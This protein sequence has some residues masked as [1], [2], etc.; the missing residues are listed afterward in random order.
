[1]ESRTIEQR[2]LS[3]PH[4]PLPHTHARSNERRLTYVL[5][6]CPLVSHLTSCTPPCVCLPLQ[7]G[8]LFVVVGIAPLI[9]SSVCQCDTSAALGFSYIGFLVFIGPGL[10]LMMLALRPID[11]R[12][13]RGAS[14][15][16]VTFGILVG[17]ALSVLVA[18]QS[19]VVAKAVLVILA[20]V[21]FVV[22]LSIVPAFKL[23]PRPALQ[24]AWVVVRAEL[25][26]AGVCLL[27]L[28]IN[29]ALLAGGM[30]YMRPYDYSVPM[31]VA[32]VVMLICGAASN[33]WLRGRFHRFLGSLG[34]SD[35]EEQQAA[36]VAA[37]IGGVDAAT[38]LERAART[39]RALPLSAVREEDL[40]NNNDTGMHA[41]T[42]EAKLGEV[43]GFV[44]HS[45]R[46]DGKMKFDKLLLWGEDLR[47][48]NGG[49]D[50]LIWL[51]KA[52][53]DQ[54]DIDASLSALPVFLAGCRELVV[55]AG[56]TYA[57]RLWCVMELF[58][59]FRMGGTTSRIK[60]FQFGRVN[61]VRQSLE[62]F[63]A[64]KAQ[65]FLPKDRQHLLAVIEAG[66]GDLVPFNSIVRSALASASER[67]GVAG[68]TAAAAAVAVP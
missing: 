27:C 56:E 51:D 25:A 59:F 15:F 1:M 63:D 53:I 64:R 18:S 32:G 48:R 8:L 20:C 35:S 30:G 57:S 3:T 12:A 13:I 43:D 61:E 44:S 60:L 34:H 4:A 6:A 47:A 42:M 38:A 22:A 10:T 58:T 33:S 11:R 37:L 28:S 66:F 24:H 39:F 41:R 65:C 46:D 62:T 21:E 67:S 52:C 9:A 19:T 54:N 7:I 36:T 50:P 45:W 55:L 29:E 31:L 26:V 2:L 17:V 23:A 5:V 68:T 40:T 49:K 16:L 14:L